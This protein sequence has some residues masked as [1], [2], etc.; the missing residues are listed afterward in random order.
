M[1]IKDFLIDNYIWILVVILITIVTIIGFIVD[2]KKSGSKKEN[3]QVPMPNN[4]NIG[5]QQTINQGPIQYQNGTMTPQMNT[6]MMDTSNEMNNNFNNIIPN[7]INNN[8]NP[9][10]NQNN[11]FNNKFNNNIGMNQSNFTNPMEENQ[12]INMESSFNNMQPMG[13]IPQPVNQMPN[14]FEMMNN[15]QSIENESKKEEVPSYQP[16]SEQK[17][18]FTPKE[19]PNFASI[20]NEINQPNMMKQ[21]EFSTSNI[22]STP[23]QPMNG[24]PQFEQIA[25]PMTMQTNNNMMSN[26]QNNNFGIN[27]NFMPN[28][29]MIPQPV[30]M[31]TTPQPVKPQSIMNSNGYNQPNMMSQPQSNYQQSNQNMGQ[32]QQTANQLPVNFVF[33]PQNNN[34]NM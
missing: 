11:N 7:N 10:F 13:T 28:N 21:P 26:S 8:F 6:N 16:L 12:T 29:N 31:V 27:P 5:N 15:M 1:N 18:K 30:N 25:Q 24:Q 4:Q 23:I 33:G 17:P 3:P 19:V 22:I 20:P 32:P 9:N 34:Q 2:K 14:N